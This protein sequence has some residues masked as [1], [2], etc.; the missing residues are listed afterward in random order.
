MCCPG[1]GAAY[2]AAGDSF[3]GGWEGAANFGRAGCAN[4][5]KGADVAFLP[6]SAFSG[7]ARWKRCFCARGFGAGATY[8]VYP[9]TAAGFSA[10]A[11][12]LLERFSAEAFASN[13]FFSLPGLD[14][15]V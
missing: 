15:G 6:S 14:G 13:W 4:T 7:A 8:G 11:A 9:D 10:T 5:L 1:A 12:G 2:F 3:D